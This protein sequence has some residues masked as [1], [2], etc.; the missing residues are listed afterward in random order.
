MP[1]EQQ[2]GQD[3]RERFDNDV[4]A[5]GGDGATDPE[6]QNEG[7]GSRSAA[8]RYDRDVERAA[9]DER[10]VESA[11]KNAEEAL[12]GPEGDELRKAEERG[13]RAQHP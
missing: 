8:R 10:H 7:E 6:P 4:A 11:A 9:K 13:K 2:N 12:E 3:E 5:S 1:N